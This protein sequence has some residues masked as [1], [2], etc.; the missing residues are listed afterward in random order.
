MTELQS[1]LFDLLCEFDRICKKHGLRYWMIGGTLLGAVRHQGFIPWDDDIDLM[2][3]EEDYRRF[4]ALS[5]DIPEYLRIQAR[6]TDTD[7]PFLFGKLCDTRVQVTSGNENNPS[8]LY[9][10]VF[11]L[12][13]SKRRN[14]WTEKLFFC[15]KA[16]D[17]IL[18]RKTKWRVDDTIYSPIRIFAWCVLG[19]LPVCALNGLRDFFVNLLRGDETEKTLLSVGGIHSAEQEFND[20]AWFEGS[21]LLSFEKGCFPAPCGWDGWL[22]QHYGDYM[23][24]PAECDRKPPHVSVVKMEK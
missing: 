16:L 21:V 14:R 23:T 5:N 9:L 10:D 11:P 24:I 3:P 6:E 12:I 1:V 15:V 4:I 22:S 17:Y 20:A 7:F 18:Q 13:C 19:W 2:M 8:G